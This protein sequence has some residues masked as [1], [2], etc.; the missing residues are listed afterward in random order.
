MAGTRRLLAAGALACLFGLVASAPAE[1]L[2]ATL[3]DAYPGLEL[4]RL[5]GP[6]YRGRAVPA[7]YQGV[8]LEEIAWHWQPLQLLLGRFAVDV[9]LNAGASHARLRS[10][11]RP[12]SA[13]SSLDAVDARVDLE[14]L[15]GSL[16]SLPGRARGRLE[17]AGLDL[18]L[19]ADG[20]PTAAHGTLALRAAEVSAPVRVELGG[21]D[22][23]IGT[24]GERLRI[25]FTTA[26]DNPVAGS[27][28]LLLERSGGY[29]LTA[30]LAARNAEDAAARGLIRLAGRPGADGRVQ[31]DRAGRWR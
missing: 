5:V 9:T 29:R 10:V 28:T 17:L 2:R 31:L 13:A 15:S 30:T 4:G 18:D 20:W 19:D 3:L 8:P 21:I 22:A 1:R 26:P 24:E 23:T 11:R 27:G 14:W 16:P 25:E 6:A 12:W 7:A